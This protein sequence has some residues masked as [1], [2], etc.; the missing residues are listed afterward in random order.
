M[1]LRT[2]GLCLALATLAACSSAPTNQPPAAVTGAGAT[3]ASTVVPG[4]AEDLAQNVGDRVFFSLDRSE[5]TA[6][7]KEVL[8]RQADWLKEYAALSVIIE[9]HCDERGGREYNF[10]LGERRAHAVKEYLISLG[11]DAHRIETI[12]YGK[13][14]PFVTGSS[15]ES[16]AQNRVGHTTLK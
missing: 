1:L 3:T 14:K 15:E 9:G 16:W 11:V 2:T 12:S 10:A 8:Q 5:L 6:E 13:E 4:S 7:A